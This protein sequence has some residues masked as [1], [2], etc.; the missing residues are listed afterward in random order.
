MPDS[1][2]CL[3]FI[4]SL[5]LHTSECII[6]CQ[7]MLTY[8]MP[9]TDNNNYNLYVSFLTESYHDTILLKVGWN[10]KNTYIEPYTS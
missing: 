9:E 6:Q 5:N 4:L 10:D 7:R 8:L 3:K 1:V 2:L